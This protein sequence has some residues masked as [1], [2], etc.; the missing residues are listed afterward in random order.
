MGGKWKWLV[1]VVGLCMLLFVGVPVLAAEP[2]AQGTSGDSGCLVCHSNPDLTYKLP[3]GEAW[4]L[5]VDKAMYDSSIHTQKSVGCASCHA[6]IKGYPHAKLTVTSVRAYQLQ[7]YQ[8][9]KQC[10]S[11]LYAKALDSV[12]GRALAG[13]NTGAAICTDCHT[14]HHTTL[15]NQPRTVIDKTCAKCHAE[16][17]KEYVGS[18][19]G[20]ALTGEGNADVPTCVDC[21]GV[22]N[23]EDPRTAQFRLNSP[24]LCAKCHAN[25]EMM[26]KYNISTYV[27]DSY[28]SD[29]HGTTITLFENQSPDV[30]TNKPVCYDCHGV[31][32]MKS[33][34]D[35][36]SQVVQQNLLKTCQKC[37]PDANVNFPA[38]WLSHY[39]PSFQKYP[40]IALVNL[41][42]MLLIPAVLGFMAIFVLLDIGGSV[43]RR[44]RKDSNHGGQV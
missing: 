38:T 7:Q 18:V 26:K 27:F 3:S 23:Q 36:N 5:F 16:I 15:P 43:A 37:H 44:F 42:Y 9:C 12:H 10:H 39:E 40:L 21:H 6:D 11:E 30:A 41:F 34:K 13:G 29:F 19:H 22:H 17:D 20:A 4:R 2:A 31:H 35:A 8:T 28:V 33:T 25:T 14:A 24:N 32:D 1:M